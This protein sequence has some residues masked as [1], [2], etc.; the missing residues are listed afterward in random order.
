[1]IDA[2]L[3]KWTAATSA[4]TSIDQTGPHQNGNPCLNKRRICTIVTYCYR[5]F[6]DYPKKVILQF[7]F[8]DFFH[9]LPAC[10]GDGSRAAALGRGR[11]QGTGKWAAYS[12]HSAF[13]A[14][15]GGAL[16]LLLVEAFVK[17]VLRYKPCETHAVRMILNKILA[18][19]FDSFS[20]VDFC[21]LRR[22][23]IILKPSSVLTWAWMLPKLMHLA[24]RIP[25]EGTTV[26]PYVETLPVHVYMQ[27]NFETLI[28]YINYI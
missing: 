20:T 13:R 9:F 23:S 7:N 2:I 18:C 8:K 5:W 10:P 24:P 26:P 28:F 16:A 1:M 17:K 15:C 4:I 6:N 14:F 11:E 25:S 19:W 21:K 12:T 22:W 3:H 27:C